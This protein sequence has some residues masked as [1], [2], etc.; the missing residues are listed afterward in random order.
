[1]TESDKPTNPADVRVEYTLETEPGQLETGHEGTL[2]AQLQAHVRRVR[3]GEMG[4]LPALAGLLVLSILFASSSSVF[5]TKTNVANLMTQTAA[6]MM[7]SVA[8]TFVIVIAEI[9]LSAG[10]T[11]GVGMAVWILLVNTHQWNWIVALVV[12]ILCGAALGLS[13]GVFV[14]KVGIPSFGI[15]L[16]LFVGLQGLMLVLLGNADAYRVQTPAV[17]AIIYKPMAVWLGWAMLAIIVAVSLGTGLYDRRRRQAAGVPV[18]PI[19]LLRIRVGAWIVLGGLAVSRLSQNRSTGIV[20]FEG[21]SCGSGSR[22]SIVRASAC[23]SSPWAAT[24]RPRG[25]RA[26]T[27]LGSRSRASSRAPPSPWF[28]GCSPSA[29]WELSRPP[30]AGT[31]CCPASARR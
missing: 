7:L 6:L 2:H 29:R 8:L 25:A 13:I 19:V 31:S 14:A 4:M 23:T 16:G 27:W 30:P 3:G 15:T 11:G 21:V 20:P 26:S 28:P 18:R 1:V 10:V 9:D 12:A 5:L 24:P 17:T 22:S